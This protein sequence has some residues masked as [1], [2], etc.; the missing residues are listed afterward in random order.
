MT[1][2]AANVTRVRERIAAA[3][4]RSGRRFEDVRLIAITKDVE[5]ERI[6]A[7]VAA[8]VGEL[9]ENRVQEARRKID[10]LGRDPRWHMVGHLQRNKAAEAAAL[11]DVIHSIDGPA[12]LRELSRRAERP[13]EVLLQVNVAGEPQKHGV[14]P[15]GLVD[16]A[17]DAAHLPGIVVVGLMTIAPIASDP[18]TA[19]PV[20]RRLRELRDE[21]NRR[22]VLHAP[23]A[24]LSMGMTD[25]FEVAIEEGATIVRIGRGIFGERC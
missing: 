11:F 25:D 20:F 6:R 15:D 2:V 19:R 14:A 12:I 16:L 22:A 5:A 24:H 4:T 13:V 8:G 17:A 9:G 7:A 1:D 3:A 18:D 21:L 10:V 23:L